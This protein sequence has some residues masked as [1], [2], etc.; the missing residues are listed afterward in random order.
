MDPGTRLGPY[1]IVEPIGAGG[2]GEVYRALDTRLGRQVAVKTLSGDVAGRPERLARFEREARLLASLNHPHI[3]SIYGIED[4]SGQPALILELVDGSTLQELIRDRAARG[5]TLPPAKAIA[6]ARQIAEALDA[7]HEKGIVHR[8]L[9]PANVKVTPEGVVKVIDFGL[10]RMV[11]SAGESD[12]SQEPTLT[13][14]GTKAG[15][16]LGTP[17]YMSPEQ[18]RGGAVD[19]RTDV[20]AFGCVLFELLA[21]TPTFDGRSTPDVL[22]Q[23]LTRDPDWSRLPQAAPASVRRLLQRCLQKDKQRRLRDIGDALLELDEDP[24]PAPGP[25]AGALG[26]RP[27]R[28]VSVLRLTDNPG[29]AV[30]PAIS[31]DGKMVAFVAVTSGRRQIFI[32]LLAGGTPLQVTRDA[33]ERLRAQLGA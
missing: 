27:R 3:G 4:A 9:K 18:A 29:A 1:E 13:S 20:W 5:E 17:A 21:G 12:A 28:D 24:D 11:G 26:G 32:Q 14:G 22:V 10:G 30:N 33:D 19:K 15:T 6:I 31:P 2:M 16:V 23:V 25:A 7:A 8:D